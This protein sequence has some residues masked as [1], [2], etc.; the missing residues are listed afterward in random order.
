[1]RHNLLSNKYILELEGRECT[2]SISIYI[3]R[4]FK[5]N[6]L[7]GYRVGI[8]NQKDRRMQDVYNF[9]VIWSNRHGSKTIKRKSINQKALS[10]IGGWIEFLQHETDALSINSRFVII[11]L[12]SIESI[13]ITY[14]VQSTGKETSYRRLMPL[15][16]FRPYIL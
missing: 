9:E 4:H 5:L 7:Y 3:G 6:I 14:R 16:C 13:S 12:K 11:K 8:Y 1:M 10:D 2:N 15:D